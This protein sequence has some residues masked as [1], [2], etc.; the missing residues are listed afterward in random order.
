M[1]VMKYTVESD[2]GQKRAI[3]EDR[4]AFFERPDGLKLA[5]V[6][7]GMGGHNA[8][9]VASEMTMEEA[10]KL[11]LAASDDHF[12]ERHKKRA[13]LIDVVVALNNKLHRYAKEHSECS[14][15]GTTL[16]MA[17]LD[18]EQ[19]TIAHVGDSRVYHFYNG[20]IEQV[21]R[22]HSYVNALVESGE[23]SEEEAQHHP[24]KNVILRAL[25]TDATIS[26]DLYDVV[27]TQDSYLLLCSDGLSNK[28]SVEEMASIIAPQGTLQKKGQQL[29]KLANASGGEDNISLVLIA[30]DEGEV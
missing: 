16:D 18:G 29:I 15:M 14:G 17:L 8:G 22:D 9:D 3:N 24:K 26:P 1:I 4:A 23:I 12:Q 19:C 10:Q 25:G 5:I 11:F 2:I 7:D 13:W 20:G 28:V 27:L 6:A 21:T 30:K